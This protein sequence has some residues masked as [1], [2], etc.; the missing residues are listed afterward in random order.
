MFSSKR[1]I[2]LKGG[3]LYYVIFLVFVVSILSSLF[4]LHRGIK[5]LQ[6]RE[7][8][9]YFERLDD[10]DSALALYFSDPDRFQRA[11]TAHLVLFGDTTRSVFIQ[12][13]PHGLL[14]IITIR[15]PY[16]NKDL[17]KCL[18]AGRSPFSGDS[19]VL[20]VPD[21][22]QALFASG[23]TVINGIAQ[24]PVKGMQRASIEGRPLQRDR[25]IDG[26]ITSSE[27]ALPELAPS[28]MEKL[29]AACELESH[30]STGS[31]I[32]ELYEASVANPFGEELR[33]YGTAEN[34]QLS[35]I[36]AHGRMGFF[37]EGTI[38]IRKDAVLKGVLVAARNILVE[39]G[40]QGEVQ[41]FA[42]D[43]LVIG[44]ECLLEFPSTACIYRDSVT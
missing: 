17:S 37:S 14:D 35:G 30:T 6:M 41:L 4:I 2:N 24:L 31:N 16:R 23:A 3:A 11:D 8:I 27:A 12:R 7:E 9:R 15:A 34:Y 21:R 19:T 20:H 22:G 43:S 40:F 36:D 26:R 33:W 29:K 18:L 5:L 28:I 1:H 39:D 32:L 38:H 13:E 10:L 42:R 44:K 25:V